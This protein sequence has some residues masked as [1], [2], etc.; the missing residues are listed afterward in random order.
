MAPNPLLIFFGWGN[1]LN[2]D[3][4]TAAVEESTKRLSLIAKAEGLLADNPP[5]LYGNYLN[6]QTPLVDMYGDN[7]PHLRTLKSK[8]DP[9]NIMG[10]A[11]GFK[12]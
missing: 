1:A 8:V 4:F 11:G 6:P 9:T 12:I 7:L 5:T 2:D 3:E 10:L